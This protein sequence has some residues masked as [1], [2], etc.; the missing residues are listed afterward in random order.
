MVVDAASHG[1][2]DPGSKA[3]I[4][5][6]YQLPLSLPLAPSRPRP[7]SFPGPCHSRITLGPAFRVLEYYRTRHGA[8]LR[9]PP[10][11]H[12]PSP[13]SYPSRHCR[14]S[15]ISVYSTLPL[16]PRSHPRHELSRLSYRDFF[17]TTR[18]PDHRILYLSA[19]SLVLHI[20]SLILS[21]S[22]LC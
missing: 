7:S 14:L 22:S 4:R 12:P 9:R 21:S 15:C 3:D 17:K 1:I 10:H 5:P 11:S 13:L 6:A 20:R 19:F 8:A 18:A 16:P 2:I